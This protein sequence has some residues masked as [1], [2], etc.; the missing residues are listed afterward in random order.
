MN[1]DVI[2]SCG[3]FWLEVCELTDEHLHP[4]CASNYADAGKI[5][6]ALMMRYCFSGDFKNCKHYPRKG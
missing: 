6:H 2:I 5:T 3:S 4:V 1:E